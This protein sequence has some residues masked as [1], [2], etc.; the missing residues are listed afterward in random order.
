MGFQLW[1]SPITGYRRK[2]TRISELRALVGSGITAMAVL[3]PLQSCINT[4]S[5]SEVAPALRRRE[6]DV[7]G[8]KESGTGPVKGFVRTSELTSGAVQDHFHP[9]E[10]QHLVSEAI[11]LHELLSALKTKTHVFVLIGS[12]V[13]GIVT[14]TDLNKPPVRIYL[15]GIISLFE[16]HLTFWL[17]TVLKTRTLDVLINENRLVSAKELQELRGQ[18]NEHVDLVECLQLC[19]KRDVIVGDDAL[20]EKL[21]MGSKDRAVRKI[22]ELEELRNRVAH[23]QQ[24]L[25]QG[26]RWEGIIELVEWIENVVGISD[27]L[28]E[29]EAKNQS[30]TIVEGLLASI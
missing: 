7:A 15:F 16:M 17:R 8:I 12:E 9:F 29:Q 4:I 25:S 10:A 14:R 20:R 26:I 2:G 11:P 3:E 30:G 13:R 5:A 23:S 21:G 27:A 6:F 22:K 19:D 28:V 1:T 18:H 24:D